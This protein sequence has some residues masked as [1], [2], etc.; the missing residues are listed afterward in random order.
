MSLTTFG[1]AHVFGVAG[2]ITNATVQ[3]FNV[4]EDFQNRTNTLDEDGNE[5]ERRMDD[6]VSSGDITIRIQAAFSIPNAGELLTYDSI[7]YE[8][9]TVGQ[10]KT[11]DAHVVVT[12]SIKTT[13]HVDLSP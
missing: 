3:S 8:I 13:E 9:I 1:T 12:L 5:I 11:N 2:T 7:E 6:I 4:T 10:A